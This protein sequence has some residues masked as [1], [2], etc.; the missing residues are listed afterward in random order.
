MTVTTDNNHLF[1]TF[2]Q[3]WIEVSGEYFP[4][5]RDDE[6]ID[7][8]KS[9]FQ[10]EGFTSLAVADNS[11]ALELKG[12]SVEVCDSQSRDEAI[13]ICSQADAGITKVEA[14]I[15][16]T[17][18]LVISAEHLGTKLCSL[19]PPLHIVIAFNAEIFPNLEAFFAK[20]DPFRAWSFITGPSRTADIEKTL[21]LGAHGPKRVMVIGK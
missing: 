2:R 16:D 18:T 6:I 9:I 8:V 11:L 1:A 3:H 10:R 13:S 12:I 14:L 20:T 15:A 7:V 19:L 4:V 5:I 21:I 17:G